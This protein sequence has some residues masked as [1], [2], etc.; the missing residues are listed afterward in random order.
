MVAM[1]AI[2]VINRAVESVGGGGGTATVVEAGLDTG[3]GTA[4][5]LVT[6][7]DSFLF[8]FCCALGFAGEELATLVR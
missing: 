3:F 2:V 4:G 7:C 1:V 6:A 5:G 8:S